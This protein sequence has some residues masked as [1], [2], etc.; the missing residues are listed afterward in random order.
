MRHVPEHVICTTSS[1]LG[2]SQAVQMCK[3]ICDDDILVT[4]NWCTFSHSSK[5]A[6]HRCVHD[7]KHS[8]SKLAPPTLGARLSIGCPHRAHLEVYFTLGVNRWMCV[9]VVATEAV[10]VRSSVGGG[11]RQWTVRVCLL[12]DALAAEYLLRTYP[13]TMRHVV[14]SVLSSTVNGVNQYSEAHSKKSNGKIQS[15]SAALNCAS[16][17]RPMYSICVLWGVKAWL[18]M[19]WRCVLLYAH[20]V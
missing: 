7:D 3:H 14:S 2:R 6:Y 5:G 10:A 13:R 18:Q 1:I 8:T 12:S 19:S 4:A 11:A 9:A 17:C 15:M 20:Q 16:C